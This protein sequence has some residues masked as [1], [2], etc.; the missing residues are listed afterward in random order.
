[1]S[2]VEESS[3]MTREEM[4]IRADAV[5]QHIEDMRAED[6]E[7]HFGETS[8]ELEEITNDMSEFSAFASKLDGINGALTEQELEYD[9]DGHFDVEITIDD[10]ED[11]TN[12]A[13]R[14]YN[15]AHG[16]KLE[17]VAR[18]VRDT[19]A[20]ATMGYGEQLF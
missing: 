18:V 6:D 9:I 5:E 4:A 19:I 1:M 3:T 13:E 2:F 17:G 14:A 20:T 10:L 8:Q 7:L 11:M 16:T 12:R 15:N